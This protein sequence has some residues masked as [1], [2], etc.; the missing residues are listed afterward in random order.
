MLPDTTMETDQTND[1]ATPPGAPPSTENREAP[2]TVG[3]VNPGLI[4]L[5]SDN[6]KHQSVAE[7]SDTDKGIASIAATA[8]ASGKSDSL[9]LR[10]DMEKATWRDC[11]T[12]GKIPR[13]RLSKVRHRNGTLHV[14]ATC[15]DCGAFLGFVPQKKKANTSTPAEQRAAFIAYRAEAKRRGYR[16][17]QAYHRFKAD[18]GQDPRPEWVA[19]SVKGGAA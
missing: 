5:T 6:A 8:N 10:V 1:T 11:P 7:L 14:Q 12:H 19:G 16:P 2:N 3:A 9:W 18:Y 4:S 15:Q 17:G 13:P